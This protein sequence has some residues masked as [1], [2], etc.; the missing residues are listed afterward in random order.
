MQKF[1]D[2]WFVKG[3]I[4]KEQY[5]T[6]LKDYRKEKEKT[7]KVRMQVALYIIGTI[8]TGFG[9]ILFISAN[10]WILELLNKLHFL[11]ISIVFLLALGSFWGGYQLRYENSKFPK[12]GSSL[13]F[14][15]TLLIGSVYN[16]I[17]QIYNFEAN[18]PILYFIWFLSVFP[19]AFIFKS[20]AINVLSCVLFILFTIFSYAKLP[21]DN[22]YIWFIYVPSLLG[23]LFYI[24]ANV[25][26]VR[27]DYRNFSV[28]YKL[29]ALFA[30][31]IVMLILTFWETNLKLELSGSLIFYVLPL[32][33]L[34]VWNVINLY[35]NKDERL[36]KIESYYLSAVLFFVLILTLAN[37]FNVFLLGLISNIFI[38]LMI[39]LQYYWGYKNDEQGFVNLANKMLAIYL[40]VNYIRFGINYHLGAFYFILGGV[41]LI[42]L[43]IYSEKRKKLK[44]E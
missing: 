27:Q 44:G 36:L 31:Y 30:I 22:E 32:C 18:A 5:L 15:S 28:L 25:K 4:S 10:N 6:L 2:R 37:G 13:I 39:Y 21:F 40:I 3:M 34:L 9:I 12:L 20:S 23:G 42:G 41:I 14:L 19:L 38:I 11:K 7:A 24:F 33:F 29:T 8:L 17:G 35:L 43:G 26:K 16:L 1:L